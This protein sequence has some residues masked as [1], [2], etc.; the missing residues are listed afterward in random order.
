VKK[1]VTFGYVV[2]VLSPRKFSLFLRILNWSAIKSRPLSLSDHS[3][4]R[5]VLEMSPWR[6]MGGSV[7]G[8]ILGDVQCLADIGVS[9][10]MTE[11]C[12]C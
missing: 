10:A 5:R 3:L 4:Q 1:L 8:M 9:S 12:V 11:V 2:G 6:V 7:E